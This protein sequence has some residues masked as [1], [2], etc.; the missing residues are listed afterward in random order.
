[1]A[2]TCCDNVVT[3]FF[4][5]NFVFVWVFLR[6]KVAFADLYYIYV[7]LLSIQFG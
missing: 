5:L 7:S 3:K 2:I 4:F 1:M 6:V